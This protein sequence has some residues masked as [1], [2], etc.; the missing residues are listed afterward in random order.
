[1]KSIEIGMKTT[2]EYTVREKDTAY[3]FDSGSLDILATP[4]LIASAESTCK[5]MIQ[6]LLEE[7]CGTVGTLVN[8]RHMAPSP[9]GIKYRCEAEVIAVEGRMIRFSVILTDEVNRIGEGI[10]ERVIINNERFT[11]KALSKLKP[12]E[13]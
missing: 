10:H 8:I 11:A 1:M 6:P 4:I 2:V 7:G 3:S 12:R 5:N 9:V 13:E